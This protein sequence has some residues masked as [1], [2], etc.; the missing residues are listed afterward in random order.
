MPAVA[1]DLQ[2][3]AWQAVGDERFDM[4]LIH[5]GIFF[6]GGLY[7]NPKFQPRLLS[8]II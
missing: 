6:P 8:G 7:F 2:C 5:S 4:F 1:L 3:F